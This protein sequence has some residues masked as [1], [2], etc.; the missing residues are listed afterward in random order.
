MFVHEGTC[1]WTCHNTISLSIIH[2][3][4]N[5]WYPHPAR[6]RVCRWI[7]GWIE[8]RK[9][10][11][12]VRQACILSP[13]GTRTRND[14]GRR[15]RHADLD[16]TRSGV[17]RERVDAMPCLARAPCHQHYPSGDGFQARRAPATRH[18]VQYAERNLHGGESEVASYCAV[19]ALLC[20]AICSAICSAICFCSDLILFYHIQSSS[21]PARTRREEKRVEQNTY[22]TFHIHPSIIFGR[23]HHHGSRREDNQTETP[24]PS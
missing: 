14:E 21:V 6:S 4:V 10:P 7:G 8:G 3:P 2:I 20:C 18:I 15:K 11:T 22:P 23:Y 5:R 19:Q 17:E 24:H 12:L 16:E 13:E 1:I 9:K